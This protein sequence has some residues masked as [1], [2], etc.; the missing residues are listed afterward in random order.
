MRHMPRPKKTVE[1]EIVVMPEVEPE[2]V[3]YYHGMVASI[4][5]VHPDGHI[6]LTVSYDGRTQV[7]K[8]RVSPE[9]IEYKKAS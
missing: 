4:V 5:A 3:P 1:P 8:G 6:D 9:S 2:L 7:P